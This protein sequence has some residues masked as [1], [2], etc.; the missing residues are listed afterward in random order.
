MARYDCDSSAVPGELR[1]RFLEQE[2][3]EFELVRERGPVQLWKSRT[4]SFEVAGAKLPPRE[5]FH[6]TTGGQIGICY[7]RRFDMALANFESEAAHG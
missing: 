4:N 5:H 3:P 6:I 1:Q 2:A 7:M